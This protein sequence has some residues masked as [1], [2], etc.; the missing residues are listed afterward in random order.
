MKL[1]DHLPGKGSE[2]L[3]ARFVFPLFLLLVHLFYRHTFD[4]GFVTD[5]TGLLMRIEGQSIAGAW[6][7]FGFPSLQPLLNLFLFL[8]VKGF[9]VTPWPWHL[10]FTTMHALNG[11]LLFRLGERLMTR[12]GVKRAFEPAL[13]GALLFLLSPYASEVLVWRVCFNFL[14]STA[15]VLGV[16]WYSVRWLET[17]STGHWWGAQGLLLAGLFSFELALA[18]PVMQLFLLLFWRRSEQHF[19]SGAFRRLHLPQWLLVAFF[20]GL[21]RLMLGDWVGHYGAEVHLRLVWPE[22]LGNVFRYLV[23]YL[24]FARYWPHPQKELVFQL[25]GRPAVAYGLTALALAALTWGW[26]SFKKLAPAGRCAGFFLLVGLAALL[27][28]ITL[29]FNYLQYIEND[30]YGYLFSAF[31]GMAI[32]AFLFRSYRPV[33][34][35]VLA[36]YLVISGVLL[37][38]TNDYWAQATTVYRALLDRFDYYDEPEIYVLNLPDNLQGAVLFRDY[39]GADG[40]LR[41]A[42]RYVKGRPYRG[43]LQEVAQYNMTRASDGVTVERDEAGTLVVTFRQ[44]GNWWWRRGLGATDYETDDYAFFNEGQAY[45]LRLKDTTRLPLLLY[46]DGPAWKTV[47]Y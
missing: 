21:S 26:R 40:G 15:L 38:R 24:A 23:K 13:G 6:N 4:A 27:P 19:P 22:M 34:L 8:F 20:F 7:S 36:A 41:D 37:W 16:L 12:F 2:N 25:I 17:Q 47:D 45:R 29:Y 14:L 42:L 18:A 31:W 5:F 3:S 35:T 30:R 43:V 10:V 33:G 44:W 32:S 28:V 46:Q 9:G 11:W 39:S 1:R